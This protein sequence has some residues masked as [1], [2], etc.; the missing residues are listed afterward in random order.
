MVFEENRITHQLTDLNIYEVSPRDGLQGL[1][2]TISTSD[3]LSLI[4]H[5]IKAGINRI[6]VGSFVNP[7]LVPNMADS[8]DV[9]SQSS[10]KHKNCELSILIPNKRGV[11]RAKSVGVEKINIFMSPSE[12]F[13]NNNHNDTTYGVFE[14]YRDALVGISKSNV[15]V[16]LSCVFG[17]PIGG[18]ITERDLIQSL[19]WAD[20]FGNTI[21][22]SDT[23]GRATSNSIKSVI[24]L[25]RNI[26]VSAK[27]ALHLHHG[28][29][30]DH[31][32]N[33]LDAAYEMGVKDFDSSI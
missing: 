19:E 17:C 11:K 12:S 21:V 30:L 23:T 28:E 32:E 22:L 14:K 29:N 3:K 9:F 6:E 7:K 1:G 27:I 16:Y 15:R 31:M 13:N 24:E 2:Y 10:S 26:G 18:D 25:S 4:E 20:S 8:E 33:K 5:I